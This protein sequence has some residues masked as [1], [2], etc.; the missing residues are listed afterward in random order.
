MIKRISNI[1]HFLLKVNNPFVDWAKTF[2]KTKHFF[3]LS[4][5]LCSLTN[6][7]KEK[8]FFNNIW[9]VLSNMSLLSRILVQM[10]IKDFAL[11]IIQILV[12]AILGNFFFFS[13]HIYHLYQ[14]IKS[15]T[16]VFFSSCT[17]LPNI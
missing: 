7:F 16:I 1:F 11:C 17:I 12:V 3:Y 13:N 5:N 8:G 4:F 15:A 2:S 9:T 10:V 6:C 14:I